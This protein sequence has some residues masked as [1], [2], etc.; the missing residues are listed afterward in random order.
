MLSQC[1]ISR[2]FVCLAAGRPH[3]DTRRTTA[4]QNAKPW[5]WKPDLQ[6]LWTDELRSCGCQ[7]V[8]PDHLF[9]P[10]H[11][12]LTV[13]TA[14]LHCKFPTCHH[15]QNVNNE[16]W[17]KLTSTWGLFFPLAVAQ[18]FMILKTFTS[19]AGKPSQ[20]HDLTYCSSLEQCVML[21][22]IYF[23]SLFRSN[24]TTVR[25]NVSV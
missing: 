15:Y 19:Q 12:F 2:A 5:L 1:V 8:M 16:I 24:Y 13:V 17:Y 25:Y 22:S 21:Y 23:S 7:Q 10:L 14:S 18:H 4:Q 6:I 20:W 3:A 11:S 9:C